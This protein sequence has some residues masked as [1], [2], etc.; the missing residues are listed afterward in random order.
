MN[1]PGD[2]FKLMRPHQWVKNIFVFVG[3]FFSQGWND[4]ELFIRA[5]LA[6]V[7]FCLVSSS[8]YVL[9]DIFDIEKDRTHVTKKE[10]P[11]AAGKVTVP[12]ALGLSLIL[13]LGGILLGSYVS[14]KL[15]IILCL[16][17]TL[18]I[19][20]SLR[21]KRVV[22]L[23]VFCVAIGFML[24]ILAGTTGL[25]IP[26]SKWLLLCGLMLTL[27]LSF[28][29][30]RSETVSLGDHAESHRE[31]LKNYGK[32]L[33]DQMITICAAAVILSYSLYTM[34]PDTI[35]IHQTEALMYTVPFVIYGIFRSLYLLH[36]WNSGGDPA[37][38]LLHDK[39]IQAA[40][41]GWVAS[42]FYIMFR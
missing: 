40:V 24:R 38:D 4:P 39:H 14:Q 8:V 34:S 17:A 3:F 21:L 1:K 32:P 29:K 25:G 30:R 12:V 10:R 28:I 27:Y 20:Y 33:L 16:Y 22:I 41:L 36:H 7:S 5:C 18:N 11:L 2:L 15:A 37:H 26:P 23:D 42:T 6:T 19:A 13:A 35:R 9:N 31:V